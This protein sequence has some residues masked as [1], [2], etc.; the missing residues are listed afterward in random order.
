ME[1]TEEGCR[2]PAC[3]QYVKLYHRK[4]TS[5]M[6]YGLILIFRENRKNDNQYIHL[7]N[8]FKSLNIPSAIMTGDIMKLR[9]WGLLERKNGEREDG[10]NRVGFYRIT[11]KGKEFVNG[12]IL[13]PKEAKVFNSKFFGFAGDKISIKQALKSKFNYEELMKV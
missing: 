7:W 12:N 8:F 4:I 5:S 3:N 11:E 1:P 9:Y 6:A 2:C 10:S 13:V